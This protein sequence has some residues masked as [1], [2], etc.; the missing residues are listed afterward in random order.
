MLAVVNSV[1]LK[2]ARVSEILT[3]WMVPA[4]TALLR[5]I[6]FLEDVLNTVIAI[7]SQRK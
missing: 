2:D 1:I 5:T 3:A 7:L 6:D 4:F